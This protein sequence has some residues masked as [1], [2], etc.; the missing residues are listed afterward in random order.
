MFTA[1]LFVFLMSDTGEIG[2]KYRADNKINT[3]YIDK[4]K[5]NPK[6]AFNL[7][8]VFEG[9]EYKVG[10][11]IYTK[12]TDIELSVMWNY[13]K[14]NLDKWSKATFE[15]ELFDDGTITEFE[16]EIKDLTFDVILKD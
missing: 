16:F 1:M 8:I 13:D 11:T 14:K 10:Q 2:T 6:T 9:K 7:K 15:L 4:I 3:C 12:K 5:C